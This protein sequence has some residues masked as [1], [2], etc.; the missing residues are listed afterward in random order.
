MEF[1]RRHGWQET[2]VP[3]TIGGRD[4]LLM[5]QGSA[6]QRTDLK[7]VM[8]AIY[9]PMYGPVAFRKNIGIE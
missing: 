2:G 5:H 7:A 1:S 9:A 6:P 4:T 3:Y 8:E